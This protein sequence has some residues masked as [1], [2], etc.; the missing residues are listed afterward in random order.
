MS[1]LQLTEKQF[2]YTFVATSHYNYQVEYAKIVNIRWYKFDPTVSVKWSYEYN[3][4]E[5]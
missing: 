3:W 4:Q 5:Q 1:T 2:G